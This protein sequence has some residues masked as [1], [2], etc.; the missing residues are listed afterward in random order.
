[1]D[2]VTYPG[3]E[4]GPYPGGRVAHTQ[5]GEG[6]IYQGGVYQGGVYQGAYKEVYEG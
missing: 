5:G 3:W 1:M 4:G 6:G 2:G